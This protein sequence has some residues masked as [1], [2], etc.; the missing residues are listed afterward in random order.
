VRSMLMESNIS[1]SVQ[2][3]EEDR[4]EAPRLSDWCI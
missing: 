1:V 2:R 3:K 4:V